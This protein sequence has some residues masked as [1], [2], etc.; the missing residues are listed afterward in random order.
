MRRKLAQ[1]GVGENKP[2]MGVPARRAN[3]TLAGPDNYSTL[4]SGE[5]RVAK[6]SYP[7]QK[8]VTWATESARDAIDCKRMLCPFR[9]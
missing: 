2:L 8:Y 1:F 7:V 6:N 4:P 9:A 5:S 3:L